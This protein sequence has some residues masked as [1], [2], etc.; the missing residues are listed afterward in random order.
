MIEADFFA[1]FMIQE[2]QTTLGVDIE[3]AYT[4]EDGINRLTRD[5]RSYGVVIFDVCSQMRS[6]DSPER[7]A[8]SDNMFGA[9]PVIAYCAE[10]DRCA[11][12]CI[13]GQGLSGH[14]QKPLTPGEVMSL[15]DQYC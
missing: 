10:E 11:Q 8:V 15:V 14:L 5:P 12:A 13:D 3:L 6:S 9:V 7:N 1:R 2:I 4:L